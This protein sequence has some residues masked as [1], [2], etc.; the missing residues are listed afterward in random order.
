MVIDFE[1]LFNAL[2]KYQATGN[3]LI[4]DENDS[5]SVFQACCSGSPLD[6]FSGVFNLEKTSVRAE[7]GNAV[8]VSSSAWLHINPSM[9]RS[10]DGVLSIYVE[11]PHFET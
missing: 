9:Y 5:I 4:T 8:V 11:S 10:C 2:G 6:R 1:H 7:H 3:P